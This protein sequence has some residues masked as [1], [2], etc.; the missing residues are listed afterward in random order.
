MFLRSSSSSTKSSNKI[1]IN[2][3][4][5]MPKQQNP[6]KSFL[7]N[8]S[9][10]R[11][12]QKNN[13]RFEYDLSKDEQFFNGKFSSAMKSV[14]NEE[15]QILNSGQRECYLNARYEHSPDSKYYYPEATS[16]RYGWL[17]SVRVKQ[18]QLNIKA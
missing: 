2:R 9:T 6:F 5:P 8:G 14:P 18:Q 1:F 10:S 17:H 16:W 7:T 13:S 3:R 15:K 4:T 12:R 11:Y